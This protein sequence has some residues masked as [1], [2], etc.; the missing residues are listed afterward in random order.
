LKYW[1]KWLLTNFRLIYLFGK[2][3][4]ISAV[5]GELAVVNNLTSNNWRVIKNG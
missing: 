2:I 5:Q 1:K 4:G 3:L